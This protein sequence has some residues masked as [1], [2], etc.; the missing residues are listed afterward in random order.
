MMKL[1]LTTCIVS[2]MLFVKPI[3]IHAYQVGM[4]IGVRAGFESALNNHWLGQ[5]VLDSMQINSLDT[6]G[7]GFSFTGG[8]FVDLQFVDWFSLTTAFNFSILRRNTI[9]I[10]TESFNPST[11][12]DEQKPAGKILIDHHTF[13]LDLIAKLHIKWFYIGFGVGLTVHTPPSIHCYLTTK[14]VSVS[15][16]LDQTSTAV[17]GLNLIFDAGVYIP[18]TQSKQHNFLIATRMTFDALAPKVLLDLYLKPMTGETSTMPAI[19]FS[20]TPFAV[21]LTVGYVYRH[22]IK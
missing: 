2:I 5:E 6:F 10:V 19:A 11:N 17:L 4:N 18:M 16:I 7:L 8:T 13:D 20:L 1:L 21:S 12:S 9:T 14:E 22:H 15:P 3:H